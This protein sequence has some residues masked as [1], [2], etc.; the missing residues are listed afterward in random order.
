MGQPVVHFG[1]VGDDAE[2]LQSFYADLFDWKIN[3]DNPQKYAVVDREGDSN[4]DRLGTGGG[5]TGGTERRQSGGTSSRRG[6]ERQGR[7]QRRFRRQSIQADRR[8][9]AGPRFRIS[10]GACTDRRATPDHVRRSDPGQPT[11]AP[12]APAA[13]RRR[14]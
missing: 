5:G 3:A 6:Q 1:T 2:K 12:R 14:E 11:K 10:R 7:S 4:A 9:P 8:S 13:A